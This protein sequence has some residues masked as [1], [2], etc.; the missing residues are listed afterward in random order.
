MLIIVPTAREAER[1]F[2]GPVPTCEMP[3][4]TRVGD[5]EVQA[6]LCGFGPAAAGALA[7][8]ALARAGAGGTLLAGICGTF[9]VDRLPVGGLF[10]A[11]AVRMHGIGRGESAFPQAP[12]GEGREAIGDRLP[13]AAAGA[14]DAARGELL[15]VA[16]PPEGAEGATSR[17][18]TYP[19]VL[20]EDMEGFAVALACARLGRSLAILRGASNVVGATAGWEH[21]LAL[22][23]VRQ[24]LAAWVEGPK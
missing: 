15:T 13:V 21:D 11:T 3:V 23:A 17:R 14:A 5:T 1:L 10:E 20:A 22:T 7:A 6:A 19:E 2:D 16:A 18:A 24:G 4:T 12:A 8:I 9:D